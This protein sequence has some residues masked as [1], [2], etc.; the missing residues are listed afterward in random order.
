MQ[1]KL[2]K[3]QP[4]FARL[5]RVAAAGLTASLAVLPLAAPAQTGGA[6]GAAAPGT[7]A[8]GGGASTGN[9]PAG[10]APAGAVAPSATA[11]LSGIS[12]TSGVGGATTNGAPI[13]AQDTVAG[14]PT[15]PG[16][17]PT[18]GSD[19]PN[20]DLNRTIKAALASSASLIEA[21]RNVEID[22]KRADE[23][24]AQGRPNLA[25][26]GSAT[27]FDAPTQ[28]AIGAQK[29]TVLGNHTELLSVAA[30]D[31]LDLL[32]TIRAAASQARLQALA[33]TF[34]LAS[35]SD[36]RVLQAQTGY[37][38][39]LRAIHQVKVA[40]T[41]LANAEAAQKVSH[42]LFAGQI[43]QKIDL[44]RANTQVEQARQNL[45]RAQNDRDIARASFND[46]VG[47]PLDAPVVV[48][49]VA[50][51]SVGLNLAAGKSGAP[52]APT[53]V[54]E[55]IVEPA[56]FSVPAG[57]NSSIDLNSEITSALSN[58]PEVLQQ[59]ALTRASDLGVRIAR[60]GLEPSF[61]V[62]A[63]GNYYPTPSFQAPRQRTAALTLGVAF[64]LYDGGVT[65]DRVAEARLR[66]QNAQTALDATKSDVALQV[67]Q[68]Y[69]NLS[70]AARQI[71]AAN[72]A[73]GQAIA[74]R[75][76]A[77]VRYEGQVGIYLEVTDAQTALVQA[78]NAQVD[79]V[80]NYLIARARFQNAVGAVPTTDNTTPAVTLPTQH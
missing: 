54:G 19:S 37:F 21:Q 60:A 14:G 52:S 12:H 56:P 72:A 61:T 10:T 43:G 22:R 45:I 76:L 31:R 44:L 65:R 17:V 41:A 68:S 42:Q 18:P 78:E 58:R 1:R 11:P 20:F 67:R 77:Q 50:G 25:L 35:I 33:D 3:E 80:Y 34:T 16:G 32:G 75:Q 79:A 4:N 46:L 2:R 63:A 66:T 24:L 40:E 48:Q 74:A 36:S 9:A 62:S 23:V 5:R 6:P 29:F 47:R 53:V 27:R 28:V 71:D 64:P 70:T 15:T 30:S 13:A 59:A 7:S 57:E 55:S 26:Q 39:L 73:L 38:T 69:L 49:D 8:P 51:V